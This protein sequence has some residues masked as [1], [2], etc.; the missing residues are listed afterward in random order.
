MKKIKIMEDVQAAARAL[1][2]WPDCK[3]ENAFAQ[4]SRRV[5]EAVV[6]NLELNVSNAGEARKTWQYRSDLEEWEFRL[7]ELLPV[8]I[9]RGATFC[10]MAEQRFSIEKYMITA[11]IKNATRKLAEKIKA[12]RLALQRMRKAHLL[13]IYDSDPA[14]I[15]ESLERGS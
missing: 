14:A 5:L 11:D 15:R 8:E 1:D 9:G 3:H 7:K 13:S 6:P 2:L 10:G 12:W 4:L